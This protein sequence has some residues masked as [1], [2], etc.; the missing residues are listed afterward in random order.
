M[1]WPLGAGKWVGGELEEY[2]EQG[3]GLR[4]RTRTALRLGRSGLVVFKPGIGK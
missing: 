1:P 3:W 4:L 2:K